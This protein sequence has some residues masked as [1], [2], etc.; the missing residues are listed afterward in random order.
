MASD[1]QKAKSPTKGR[2][3]YGEGSIYERTRGDRRYFVAT[4]SFTE[5]GRRRRREVWCADETAA[6]KALK[7][8]K[9]ARVK[10]QQVFGQR[11]ALGGWLDLWLEQRRPNTAPSTALHYERVVRLHIKPIVGTL[12]LDAVKPATLTGLYAE[13]RRRGTPPATVKRVHI[14]LHKA[15]SDALRAEL[16]DRNPASLAEKPR[17]R[18]K[19]VDPYTVDELRRFLD[20]AARDR[21][22]ALWIVAL[23][24]QARE[25]E[26]L[27]LQW[28]DVDF[29][30]STIYVRRG[31]QDVTYSERRVAQPKTA[32]SRRPIELPALAMAA[33]RR[34]RA[35]VD[36]T[37]VF[38][39]SRGGHLRRHNLLRRH[40][41]PV[42]ARARRCDVCDQTWVL[43]GHLAAVDCRTCGR[44]SEALRRIHFHALRHS[45]ATLLADRVP[46]VVLK[47][48]LGHASITT[49]ANLYVH[50]SRSMGAVAV[51][52]LEQLFPTVENLEVGT[53]AGKAKKHVAAEKR[54]S[55]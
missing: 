11:Q 36:G 31:L 26:L 25:G 20:A 6:R 54:K 16:V 9:D 18:S 8:L 2:R 37:L 35:R 49:T 43:E 47:E 7:R 21:L 46:L 44:S 51:E 22:E 27:A 1:S 41:Y 32:S 12:K 23:L 24:S 5:F 29:E 19:E 3:S 10:G 53:T 48:R 52:Q 39:D 17:H 42:M 38:P 40:L 13:L 28:S 45:G 4:I 30:S 15:F 33:L 34:Q 55:A 50:R 14:I